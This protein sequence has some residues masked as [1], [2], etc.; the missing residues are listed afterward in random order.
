MPANGRWDLI[1]RL[2]VKLQFSRDFR[3]KYPNI[4]FHTNTS[5]GSRVVLCGRADVPTDVPQLTVA[6]PNFAN[7]P[8]IEPSGEW[9]LLMEATLPAAN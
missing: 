8:K 9:G 4:K 3:K 1:R 5:S 7:A 6:Y 2:K